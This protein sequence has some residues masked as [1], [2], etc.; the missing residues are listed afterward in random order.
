M[1]RLSIGILGSTG[2]MGLTLTKLID[3]SSQFM[4]ASSLHTADVIVDFS[5]PLATEDYLKS[6]LDKPLIIG[7]TGH[8]EQQLEKVLKASQHIPILLA[9]NFSLG[10]SL[11]LKAAAL[12]GEALFS[13]AFI[14]IIETHHIH[15]KDAPSGTALA[16]AKTINP[17]YTPVSLLEKRNANDIVIHSIRAGETVGEHTIIFELQGEQITLSHKVHSREAFASGALYAATLL[18][19]KAP[20]LYNLEDIMLTEKASTLLEPSKM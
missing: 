1:N 6:N 3:R 11:C 12:L 17:N 16:L 9:P 8:S 4:R 5:H 2:R 19:R 18:Q 15:K 20:G 7:T 14:D 13:K 10:L